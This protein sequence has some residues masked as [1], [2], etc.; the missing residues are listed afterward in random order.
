[1][2]KNPTTMTRWRRH[3]YKNKV[4]FEDESSIKNGSVQATDEGQLTKRH[5][6]QRLCPPLPPVMKPEEKQATH[7]QNEDMT[8]DDFDSGS[9]PKIYKICYIISM[10]PFEYDTFTKVTKEEDN[11][12]AE[13]QTKHELLC[14]YVMKD[15]FVNEDKTIFEQYDMEM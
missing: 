7:D 1:M 8:I 5:V 9:E 4:A 3:Q 13:E 15:G 12:Q 14:Y 6:R 10:L 11:R 2:G